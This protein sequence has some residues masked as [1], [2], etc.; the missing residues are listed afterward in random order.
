MFHI[1]Q[2]L[3]NRAF[4]VGA[5]RSNPFSIGKCTATQDPRQAPMRRCT[6]APMHRI[7]TA[8]FFDSTT[9]TVIVRHRA[10]QSAVGPV[11]RRD[12]DLRRSAGKAHATTGSE[13]S[14]PTASTAC[15]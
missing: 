6:D 14:L 7:V 12:Y 8:P 2:T 13:N 5:W 1:A 4:S 3:R 10:A 15:S 11:M 9:A